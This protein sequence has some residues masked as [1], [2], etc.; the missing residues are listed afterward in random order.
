LAVRNASLVVSAGEIL[1]VAGVDGS[2]Q[3]ELAEAV[4]GLLSVDSGTIELSSSSGGPR[5]ALNRMSVRDRQTAG[6]AYIPEDRHR[7][8]LALD[9]SVAENYLMGHERAPAWGGGFLLDYRKMTAR[10][11]A[12]VKSYD[13]RMGERDSRALVRTLS[14][15]NQQKIVIARAIEGNP[16]LLVA[17]QPTRGLDV[18]AARFVYRTLREAKARGLGILLFSL[19]LD[20]IMEMSD[21]IA[22]MFNGEIAG[23]VPRARATPEGIGALMTGAA[24]DSPAPPSAAGGQQ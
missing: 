6:V 7:S 18:E 14:G 22:V 5:A 23:I 19:D 12:M 20:E 16:R 15:G 1:G 4:I 10:A 3:R 17:S 21:R 24:K 8:A 13:V 9:F 11:D 2:G